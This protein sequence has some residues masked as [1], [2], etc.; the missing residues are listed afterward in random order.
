MIQLCLARTK[1]IKT[2]LLSVVADVGN[3]LSL[4][5]SAS[6][7]PA[8]F[9]LVNKARLAVARLGS[10]TWKQ[11]VF[12]RLLVVISVFRGD[13]LCMQT[14]FYYTD[15]YIILVHGRLAIVVCFK[16]PGNWRTKRA[17]L[18]QMCLIFFGCLFKHDFLNILRKC[19]DML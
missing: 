12:S 14:E 13:R 18:T 15:K 19:Y 7:R 16:P 5:A 4:R 9:S 6:R 17:V 3:C 2:E 8:P 11:I 10:V 1:L